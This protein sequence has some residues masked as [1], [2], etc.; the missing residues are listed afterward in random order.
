MVPNIFNVEIDFFKVMTK[1]TKH[2]FR[3]YFFFFT[4]REK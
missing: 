3:N 2:E 4:L 1:M